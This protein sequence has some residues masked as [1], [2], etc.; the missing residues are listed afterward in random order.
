MRTESAYDCM[1]ARM[2]ARMHGRMRGWVGE[3][4]DWIRVQ[5]PWS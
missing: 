1:V 4:H 2:H 3:L 5:W